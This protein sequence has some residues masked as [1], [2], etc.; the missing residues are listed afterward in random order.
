MKKIAFL[1]L[2]HTDP[3]QLFR[4][5][6]SL[7]VV[8]DVYIHLD[9]KTNGRAFFSKKLPQNVQ[10]IDDRVDVSW[11][12]F[13][14]VDATLRMM[15]TA[16]DSGQQYSHFMMLSGLDY[17][18]KPLSK[19]Q[20]LLNSQ[21]SHEFIK[22]YDASET[23]YQIYFD[24]YWFMERISFIKPKILEKKLRHGFGRI[25]RNF[26]KKPR[27]QGLKMCW[28]SA[29]W[30]ITPQCVKYILDYCIS[31]PEYVKWAKSCFAIDELFFH[32]IIA[33]SEYFASTDGFVE[34]SGRYTH[35][36]ANLHLIHPSLRKVFTE[37]DFQDLQV[38]DKYFVRKIVSGQSD[39]LVARLNSEILAHH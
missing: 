20:Q 19:L 9:V 11:A 4:L 38:S 28:G 2:A 36:T 22:F 23:D 8:G 12:A 7:S 6:E 10:F 34:Y 18:I 17:P 1:I 21:P 37:D 39:A 16:L 29:Y 25:L 14:Q 30:A 33:N 35:K 26:I 27:P 5:S 32:T 3:S 15:R 31:H 13:S 24:Y